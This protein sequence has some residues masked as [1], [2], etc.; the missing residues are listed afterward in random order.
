MLEV[1]VVEP[2]VGVSV[3]ACVWFGISTG[4]SCLGERSGELCEVWL[5]TSPLRDGKVKLSMAGR[6]LPRAGTGCC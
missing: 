5:G 4:G 3:V 2:V 1:A 6:E